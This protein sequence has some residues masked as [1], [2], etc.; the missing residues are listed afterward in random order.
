[1]VTR[2]KGTRNNTRKKLKKKVRERGKISIA[3]ALR[4]YEI[5][6]KVAID[7]EPAY[8]KGIPH[9]R[10]FGKIGTVKGKRGN[11]YVISVKIGK[12]NKQIICPPIHLKKI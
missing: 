3:K 12:A 7:V 8:Q 4:T 5:N 2:S 6:D 11:S 9:R 10:F 1:M